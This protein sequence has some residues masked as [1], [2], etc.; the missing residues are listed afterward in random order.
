ME[1]LKR[2]QFVPLTE[3]FY[4][5]IAGILACALVAVIIVRWR[6]GKKRGGESTQSA[7]FVPREK[8]AGSIKKLF[9]GQDK[10]IEDVVPALEEI[11]L[12]AD[13][14][15]TATQSLVEAV[16]ANKDLKSK[17]AIFEFLKERIKSILTPKT[18]FEVNPKKKPYVIYLV[19]VNGVGKTTTI[20]KLA[21]QFTAKGLKVMMVAADTFR[22]AAVT[23]L[24]IWAERNHVDFTGGQPQ[25]DPS[26]V[27]VD[28]LRSAVSKKSDVVLVDTA[29]RLQTK[30]NL[31]N[32]LKKMARMS[33]KVLLRPPDEIFLVVD[34]ITGQNGFSQ[35]AVFTEA[36]TLTGIIL[37]KYD[38]TSKGGIILSIVEQTGLPIRYVGMGEGI[39][40][41]KGFDAAEFVERLFA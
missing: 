12:T 16:L 24:K 23:Q 33:D 21:S 30:T 37:T 20:G 26:S 19:G 3:A 31:M 4:F 5:I 40:D 13:V 15:I 17:E 14:G 29:G 28:G 7:L 9:A 22:A 39:E 32:E 1:F 41:L 25:S 8:F 10:K 2:L 6:K 35:A 38:A 27:I 18:P 11:L 36:V 34:A